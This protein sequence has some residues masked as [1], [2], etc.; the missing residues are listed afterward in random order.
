MSDGEDVL[1]GDLLG[2]SLL[3]SVG[4][5]LLLG[6]LLGAV[7]GATLASML[8]KLLGSSD[9]EDGPP[10]G[11]SDFTGLGPILG[12]SLPVGPALGLELDSP[13][14]A[15][16]LPGGVLGASLLTS[17][18]NELLLGAWLGTMLGDALGLMLGTLLGS[19][20]TEDGPPD[21]CPDL[22]KLGTMLGA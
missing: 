5:E 10:V 1:P 17:V 15:N 8:G 7:L 3:A 2:K 11:S 19:S 12:A 4:N 21:G 20:D 18:G 13:E 16:V 14:G 9:N 6:T 22:T